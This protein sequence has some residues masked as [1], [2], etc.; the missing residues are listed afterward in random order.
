MTCSPVSLVLSTRP[1]SLG[2]LRAVFEQ[3]VRVAIDDEVWPAVHASH[4]TVQRLAEGNEPAYGINTG[5]GLLANTRIPLAE[6]N[7]LQ[8]N[9]VL[10]HSAGVGPLLDDAVVRL[11]LL[12]KIQSFL[13]GYSG[14]S[15]PLIRLLLALLNAEMYPCVPAQGSVGASGDLAPLAHLSLPLIGLGEVRH[16]GRILC[17]AAALAQLGLSPLELGPKEGLALLNGTQVSTALALA[18]LFE[19]ERLI[20]ASTVVG[21]LSVDAMKGSDAPFD[22]RLQAARGHRGQ[23][24]VA[25]V[26]LKLM[27]G[28]SIRESHRQ[29]MRVQDPYSLRCQPQVVGAC[30]DVARHVAQM[31]T[32][33]ANAVTDNPLI[34]ASTQEVLSGGNF[35]GEPVAFGA[36]MLAL[37]IAELGALSERRIAL[38]IDPK[39]SGLPPFLTPDSGVNSG[40]MIPQVTAAALVAENRLLAHPASVDSIPTSANWEDHVS[41]ATHAARRLLTMAANTRNILA[42]EFLCAAQGIDFHAPAQA[43]PALQRAHVALRRRV[44]FMH[45]DRILAPDIEAAAEVLMSPV[46]Q[47]L[48][49]ELI[50]DP[51]CES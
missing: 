3:P 26:L 37:A 38:L 17:G 48:A 51:T 6:R 46:V 33:E 7:H 31:L 15:E 12:L 21:A 9:I 30:L 1:L 11:V 18:A 27:S 40:F 36:D 2:Q 35:H 49:A 22:P 50:S 39:L 34:V 16:Q 25:R 24:D 23:A 13:R 44:A 45:E 4:A 43:S 32:V 42:I 20:A 5:F 28:S 8:R 41:M 14:V 19:V 10:S 29:C 47:E